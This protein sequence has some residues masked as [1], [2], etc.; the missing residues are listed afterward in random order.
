MRTCIN[1]FLQCIGFE[2]NMLQKV[3]LMQTSA[4]EMCISTS[5]DTSPKDLT[6]L[7]GKAPQSINDY[8]KIFILKNPSWDK[9][10][11]CCRYP[12]IPVLHSLA[13]YPCNKLEL[14]QFFCSF[15]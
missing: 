12:N 10:I 11:T 8:F 6:R 14:I 7:V 3:Q 15:V 4:S 9:S 1:S 5:V 13:I 2:S